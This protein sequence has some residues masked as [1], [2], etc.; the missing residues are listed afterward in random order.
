[1]NAALLRCTLFFLIALIA[2]QCKK[3][4]ATPPPAEEC[5]TT[6]STD[7]VVTIGDTIPQK[8]K[9][10]IKTSSGDYLIVGT[11]LTAA[12]QNQL[13][14]VKWDPSTPTKVWDFA[15]GGSG[16]EAGC[17]VLEATDGN[18]LAVGSTT[19]SGA[20]MSDVFLIK[21]D[22]SGSLIWQQTYGG[23]NQESVSRIVPSEDGNYFIIGTTKSFGNGSRDAYLIKVDIDGNELWSKTFGGTNQ[24]G[25]MHLAYNGSTWALFCYTMSVGAGDRD[26]WLVEMDVNG[27]SLTSYTYGEPGYEEA[28]TILHTNDGGYLLQ[29][30][31]A[32]VDNAHNMYTIKL[33]ASFQVEWTTEIGEDQFHDGGQGAVEVAGDYYLLGYSDSYGA[34]MSD[35]LIAKI[36]A[37]GNFVDQQTFGTPYNQEASGL[38]IDGGQLVFT[39]HSFEANGIQWVYHGSVEAF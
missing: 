25:G 34:G 29:G 32:S 39:G 37:N 2:W 5:T 10:A 33:D 36:D 15:Y 22:P 13:L 11:R 6:P 26:F 7:Y 18:Y 19:S 12:D 9:R 24:D 38:F 14:L 35:I 16:D 21:T 31:S 1:M 30:H 8:G 27:D 17:D 3:D 20:G 4:E 23:A 28:Q